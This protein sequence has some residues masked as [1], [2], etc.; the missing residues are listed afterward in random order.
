MLFALMFPSLLLSAQDSVA[1]HEAQYLDSIRKVL[2]NDYTRQLNRYKAL[3]EQEAAYN[4]AAIDSLEKVTGEMGQ[5]I[6]HLAHSGRVLRS[7]IDALDLALDQQTRVIEAE[8]QRFTRLLLVTG[9]S[10]LIL[11]LLS[12]VLFFLL[13]RRQQESTD[14]KIN[15]L[16]KY[17]YTEIEETRT[18]LS[19]QF[20]KRVKKLRENLRG[21]GGKKKEKIPKVKTKKAGKEKSRKK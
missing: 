5:E 7:E 19:K 13:L 12:T 15:A 17:T 2:T 4:R 3:S 16:K 21:K 18:D 11:L 1:F 9:P 10:L 14:R 6:Q 8:R 20:R